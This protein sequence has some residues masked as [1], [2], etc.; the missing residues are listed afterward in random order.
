M[1]V[2]GVAMYQLV[3]WNYWF[4][5]HEWIETGGILLVLMALVAEIRAQK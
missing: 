3:Q 4:M 5:V 1:I 2:T